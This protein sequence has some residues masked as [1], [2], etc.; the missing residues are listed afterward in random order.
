[1]WRQLLGVAD[2][3]RQQGPAAVMEA[4]HKLFHPKRVALCRLRERLQ[5]RRLSVDAQAAAVLAEVQKQEH[6]WCKMERAAA[7]KEVE[8]LTDRLS[9]VNEIRSP[10]RALQCVWK[11]V[12][13]SFFHN[14]PSWDLEND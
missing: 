14:N 3:L 7:A 8:R 13:F 10:G 6:Y 4:G 12:F 2:R 5:T 11:R 9:L 1:M